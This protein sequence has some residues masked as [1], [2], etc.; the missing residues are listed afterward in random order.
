M[1]FIYNSKAATKCALAMGLVL[2]VAA[3]K[4]YTE[5][6]PL[7]SLSEST[8]FTTPANI[9]LAANGMYQAAAVGTYNGA[10][11][12][13]YPFG[14][15]AIQQGEMRGEDMVNLQAFYDLT[16]R[17]L[18]TATSANNVNHWEQ[19]YA[20]INQANILINGVKTA[21][22]S[23]IIEANVANAY[24]GE[25]RFIRA[26]SHHELLIHFSRP[27]ADNNGS[28]PG[29]P[30]RVNPIN[31]GSAVDEGLAQGRG[32]VAEAYAK[33]LEDLNFAE[34]NLPATQTNGPARATSGAAIALKT[35]IKLHMQDWAGV[36]AEGAKMGTDLTGAFKSPVGGY[37]LE[38]DPSTPFVSYK[39]NKESIFSVANSATSNGGVNGALANMLG[40]SSKSARDLVA[41]SPNLY[42]ADFWVED[43]KR[44]T[45]L[46]I[47]QTTGNYPYFY[48]Y[49]YREYGVFGDWAPVIR[50]AEVLL[51]VAEAK[52]RTANE[53]EAFA[54]FNAVRNR[55][56]GEAEQFAE[57]PED[58]IQAILNERRIE[59][60]GEG[61][62]W[63]DIH[64]LVL[65]PKYSTGG[66]P[67]KIEVSQ[68]KNS[69]YDT[70]TRPIT[71]G[72]VAAIP[73]SDFRFVWPIPT[74]ETSTN[75]T[76]AKEQNPN[77]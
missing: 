23:G 11:G 44:R 75:Q 29:V 61:R 55:S 34:T 42:N 19:L 57:A 9:E 54:L 60:T 4:D 46:Q 50:Y 35:R 71:T 38:P 8:A 6:N 24:E 67:A 76:L 10:A 13:G 65:D 64:R 2:S 16:Y 22:E 49:K 40:P 27:F 20:L 39:S 51:N 31:S 33:I 70:E 43:D 69:L 21:G 45:L 68:M 66:I 3:C 77:Y 41:T 62:R 73:Y 74:S 1:K 14:A 59:F 18:Y 52:A 15:A 72:S 63:S 25:G 37:E 28:S 58:L 5:L 17:A 32:T 36:I 7:A 26:L 30:Y 12:R 48:S 47:G 53:E 56:V